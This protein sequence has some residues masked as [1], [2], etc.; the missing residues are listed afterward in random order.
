[1]RITIPSYA[2][3]ENGGGELTVKIHDAINVTEEGMGNNPLAL[4]PPITPPAVTTSGTDGQSAGL[5]GGKGAGGGRTVVNPPPVGYLVT[6]HTGQLPEATG[7]VVTAIAKANTPAKQRSLVTTLH[8]FLTD[9]KSDI[10][11]LNRDYKHFTVL[12]V[13]PGNYMMK[14]TY[15]QPSNHL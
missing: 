5:A 8:Q 11:D 13:V 14:F 15:G 3:D 12:V 2:G 7:T 4:K 10:W 6:L 1:M 9:G